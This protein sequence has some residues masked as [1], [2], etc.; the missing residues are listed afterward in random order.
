MLKT[1]SEQNF[2]QFHFREDETKCGNAVRGFLPRRLI[3]LLEEYLREYRPLLVSASDPGTLFLN[4]DGLALG[5]QTTTDTIA[6]L[7]LTHT[8]VRVTPHVIRDIFS[9]AWLEEHPH[10]FLTLSKLLFHRSLKHTLETYG[11]DF[12]ESNGARSVD[13]WLGA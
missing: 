3:P 11:A 10:D 6:E 4:R 2:W 13:E 12:D 8:G 1:N 9:Y 7:T 5:R